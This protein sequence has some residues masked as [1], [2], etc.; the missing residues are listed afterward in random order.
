M[1]KL[2][3]Q[4]D[5]IFHLKKNTYIH[6]YKEP[7][8]LKNLDSAMDALEY[9]LAKRTARVKKK[10]YCEFVD[11]VNGKY[12]GKRTV[13]YYP[14]VAAIAVTDDDIEKAIIDLR[15]LAPAIVETLGSLWW[16]I[17]N[18]KEDLREDT[19]LP[20]GTKRTELK[21]KRIKA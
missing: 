6:K 3:V 21:P 20:L 2:E 19:G 9:V 11:N 5:I 16:S 14:Y 15:I 12:V 17:T 1:K 13:D 10:I 7:F 18:D 4:H 8:I